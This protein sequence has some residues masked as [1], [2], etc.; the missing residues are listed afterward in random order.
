MN[1][2]NWI[3]I[4]KNSKTIYK[5]NNY[6][7]GLFIHEDVY[8]KFECCPRCSSNCNPVGIDDK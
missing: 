2:N 8:K 7:C 1:K 4:I 3:E 6:S 5:C